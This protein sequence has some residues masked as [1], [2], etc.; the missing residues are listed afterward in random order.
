[1]LQVYGRTL[2][3]VAAHAEFVVYLFQKSTGR[4]AQ[5]RR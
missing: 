3:S 4:I 5:G 2:A 1:V